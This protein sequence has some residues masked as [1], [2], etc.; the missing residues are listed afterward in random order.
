[1]L[2]MYRVYHNN[3]LI[4]KYY[5]YIILQCLY[6]MKMA[7]AK[8]NDLNQYHDHDTSSDTTEEYNDE[9]RPRIYKNRLRYFAVKFYN[10]IRRQ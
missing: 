10:N 3:I 5:W 9:R 6:P 4:C 8:S 2:L 7:G 1:M